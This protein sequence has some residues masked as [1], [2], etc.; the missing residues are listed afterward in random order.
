MSTVRKKKEIR[1]DH[2]L[3]ALLGLRLPPLEMYQYINYTQSLNYG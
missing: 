3:R 2:F 1:R